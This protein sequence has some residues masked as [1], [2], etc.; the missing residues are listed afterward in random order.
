MK[1]YY[2]ALLLMVGCATTIRPPD[3]R[4]R[5]LLIA[6]PAT[7][8]YPAGSNAAPVSRWSQLGEY[9]SLD[10]CEALTEGAANELQVPVQ[11]VAT[12]DPRLKGAV[13][14]RIASD[15]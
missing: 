11:C 2:V 10:R 12:D 8:D 7:R 1:V 6:S 5:W 15:R 14:V 3:S 9:A 4:P 13:P